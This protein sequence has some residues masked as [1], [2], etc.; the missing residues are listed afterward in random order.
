MKRDLR[1]RQKLSILFIER[2]ISQQNLCGVWLCTNQWFCVWFS[3]S[4]NLTFSQSLQSFILFQRPW[5]RCS[6]QGCW[7]SGCKERVEN[8]SSGWVAFT[9]THFAL[10][11]TRMTW[12]L[13]YL[14]NF[15]P[16]GVKKKE[17]GEG[18]GTYTCNIIN[19]RKCDSLESAMSWHLFCYDSVIWPAGGEIA[20]RQEHNDSRRWREAEGKR[21]SVRQVCIECEIISEESLENVRQAGRQVGR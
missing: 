15:W 10:T 9:V 7:V 16:W 20:A 6:T 5:I 14:F 1:E 3:S 2:V 17:G 12:T 13:V 11:C 4:D 19:M 21:T 18:G 8:N